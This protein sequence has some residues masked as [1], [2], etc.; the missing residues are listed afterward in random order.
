MVN[1]ITD[2][3]TTLVIG[4]S[5]GRPSWFS[6]HSG[7]VRSWPAVKVVTMISSNDSERQHAPGQQRRAEVRQDHVTE[8]LPAVGAEIHRRF[9]Q[10][11]RG[12]A[13]PGDDVVEHDHHTERRMAD[14]DSQDTRLDV[15]R[16]ERRQ[17][18]QH[19]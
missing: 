11:V 1:S 18:R 2:S 7:S 8:G 5:R 19:R 10:A 12:A 14:D 15:Q 6:S 17:Q 3:A 4:T 16:L 13:E 9:D